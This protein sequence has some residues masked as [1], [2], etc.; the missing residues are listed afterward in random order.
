MESG[1][2]RPCQVNAEKQSVLFMS[3]EAVMVFPSQILGLFLWRLQE[4]NIAVL[5]WPFSLPILH[6]LCSLVK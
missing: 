2:T 5:V 3:P 6:P 1:R 4:K